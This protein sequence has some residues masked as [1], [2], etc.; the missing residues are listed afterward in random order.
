MWGPI[1]SL[2]DG[3]TNRIRTPAVGN[4]T[5]SGWRIR[6]LVHAYVI[7]ILLCTSS[8][9]SSDQVRQVEPNWAPHLPLDRMAEYQISLADA[10]L[11]ATVEETRT[12]P[13]T[14]RSGIRRKRNIIRVKPIEWLRGHGP[15]HEVDI[16][17]QDNPAVLEQLRST[18]EGGP[19]D[20]PIVLC[21]SA[22]RLPLQS[23]E[24]SQL[25]ANLVDDS[26]R[27]GVT[28]MITLALNESAKSATRPTLDAI[29]SYVRKQSAD[30]LFAEVDLVVVG[31]AADSFTACS[32]FGKPTLCQDVAIDS[33]LYGESAHTQIL[34]TGYSYIN[35]QHDR[36]LLYLTRVGPD[37]YAPVRMASGVIPIRHNIAGKLGLP[38]EEVALQVR[39]EYARRRKAEPK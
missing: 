8:Y 21:I 36:L 24:E 29:R 30:S 34:V 15:L 10:V 28:G 16:E 39:A 27:P 1:L 22:D 18:L 19:A 2:F 37:V 23:E 14:A 25:L 38:L 35:W 6:H 5:H 31:S 26:L 9:V 32:A 20:N 33:V 7:A 13:Y 3:T 4:M 11:L 12:I 17:F